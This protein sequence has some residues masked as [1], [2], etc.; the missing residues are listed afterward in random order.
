MLTYAILGLLR[1]GRLVHGYELA[2]RYRAV[3]AS[4]IASGSF[5]RQLGRMA[6]GG[7]IRVT[8][9]RPD[10]DARRLP[11]RITHHG[12]GTFDAWLMKPA[13]DDDLAMR[14]LFVG[15][16][17][18]A[19]RQSLLQAWDA[20]IL[21]VRASIA[22]EQADPQTQPNADPMSV[23]P[24]MRDRHLRMLDAERA[25]VH[26]LQRAYSSRRRQ[27]LGDDSEASPPSASA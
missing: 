4:G 20:H 23:L 14:G 1:D 12:A 10:E 7:L 16:L 19:T 15:A 17:D 21:T 6:A 24:L 22:T 11:Y 3:S 2:K 27:P 25:F 9:A 13:P 5:Y 26:S 8:T 18:V